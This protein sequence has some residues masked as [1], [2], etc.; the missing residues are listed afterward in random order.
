M[1]TA[2]GAAACTA[3]LSEL[4]P[5]ASWPRAGAA[6]WRSAPVSKSSSAS[7]KGLRAQVV[8]GVCV[9]GV[10]EGVVAH[11]RLSGDGVALRV[12][13]EQRRGG[14]PGRVVA[15]L[16]REVAGH[17]LLGPDLEQRRLDLGA[18]LLGDRAAG[19]EPA[20]RWRVDRAGDVAGGPDGG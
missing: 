16:A 4:L 7:P 6:G 14:R 5:A 11:R 12:H 8:P 3:E 20:A 13:A 17:L 9:A 15:D 10:V 2:S 19:A 18:D 1:R